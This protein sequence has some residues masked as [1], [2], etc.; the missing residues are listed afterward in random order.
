M[1]RAVEQ[2]LGSLATVESTLSASVV[3]ATTTYQMVKD[4]VMVRADATGG[5]FT[6]T[7]PTAVGRRGALRIIKRLNSG[8]NA[9]TVAAAAGQ[10]IDGT[11]TISLS[12][13]YMA[14]SLISNGVGWD[15]W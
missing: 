14:V 6:V 4:D 9:V 1:R 8:A 13:Q 7:L 3:D 2:A 5:A 10:T 11:S 15:V 12:S